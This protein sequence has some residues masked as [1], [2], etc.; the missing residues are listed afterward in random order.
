M[1]SQVQFKQLN[2]V[3][4]QHLKHSLDIT[5]TGKYDCLLHMEDGSVEEWHVG[6]RVIRWGNALLKAKRLVSL[7]YIPLAAIH[8]EVLKKVSHSAIED[9]EAYFSQLSFAGHKAYGGYELAIDCDDSVDMV[10]VYHHKAYSLIT[11]SHT[12]YLATTA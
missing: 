4:E 7:P 8:C 5:Y 10:Q 12:A 1:F 11:H 3:Y 2:W 9:L 6:P